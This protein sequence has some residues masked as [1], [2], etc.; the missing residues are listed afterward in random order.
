MNTN[1]EGL[2]GLANQA[3]ASSP[4]DERNEALHPSISS[5]YSSAFVLPQLHRYG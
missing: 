5:F 1:K 4:S 2:L 3:L